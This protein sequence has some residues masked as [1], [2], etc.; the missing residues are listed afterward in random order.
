MA[1]FFAREWLGAYGLACV[2]ALVLS[3]PAH[4]AKPRIHDFCAPVLPGFA[5]CDAAGL[6]RHGVKAHAAA[7]GSIPYGPADIQDA[8][9]LTSV[10]SDYGAD[11]TVAVVDAYDLPTAESDLAYY[12]AHYGLPPC[13]TASGCFRKV[14]QNGGTS[15]PAE[16][17]GWGDEIALD[18]DAVSATCPNCHILL[19]EASSASSSNLA[20]AVDRAASMGATQISNSYGGGEG[21]GE[22]TFESYYDHPGIAVTVSSGDSG[23]GVEYPAASG[24]VTAVPR[25]A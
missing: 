21:A 23:Y 2:L 22:T 4:A 15:Y 24:Y 7:L 9:G 12:R 5:H 3:A 20:L 16:D 25:L 18:L 19:V 6:K 1:N 17:T 10:A 11:Q 13:T 8:Y 14:N